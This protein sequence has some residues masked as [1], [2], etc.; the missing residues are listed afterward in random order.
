MYCYGIELSS[1]DK[2]GKFALYKARDLSLKG[3]DGGHISQKEFVPTPNH[4]T[5]AVD[6]T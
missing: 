3:H 4:L 6:T 1:M 2:T 5:A